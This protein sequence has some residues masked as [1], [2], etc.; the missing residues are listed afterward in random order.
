M[1]EGLY[2]FVT[3]WG[4]GSLSGR[5][6]GVPFRRSRFHTETGDR[7]VV[8]GEEGRPGVSRKDSGSLGTGGNTW[9]IRLGTRDLN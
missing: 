2:S 5:T 4:D 9:V 6:S 3:R 7:G 8:V 1:T